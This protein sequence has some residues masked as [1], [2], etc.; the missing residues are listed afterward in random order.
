MTRPHEFS[1]KVKV[2]AFERAG[3]RCEKCT[4]RLVPG[5]FRF[6]HRLPLALGG[7]ST[8][9]NCQCVCTSCDAPKTYGQD[10]PAIRKADRAQARHIGAKTRSRSPLPGGRDS[11]FK[12]KLD[13]TVV[14][15]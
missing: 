9:D 12:R 10:I 5:K 14:P 11:K 15:R 2:A 3:G 7:E 13:G 6:D 8:L 1:R 4:A